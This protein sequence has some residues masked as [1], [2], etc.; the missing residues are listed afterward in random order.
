MRCNNEQQ[1]RPPR[2]PLFESRVKHKSK[3]KSWF[4]PLSRNVK[5]RESGRLLFYRWHV[6][7]LWNIT[8]IILNLSRGLQKRTM[9]TVV[10]LLPTALHGVKQMHIVKPQNCSSTGIFSFK[11]QTHPKVTRPECTVT[12][13][14]ATK[15]QSH[16]N[17]QRSLVNTNSV[18]VSW[19]QSG[20]RRVDPAAQ[21]WRDFRQHASSQHHNMLLL[22][23]LPLP[24][25]A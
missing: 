2:R 20:A 5:W 13:V 19:K 21:W 10:L 1:P 15:T 12:H 25:Q 18:D 9:T 3:S 24:E 11:H 16:K 6:S 22:P 7:L 4:S 8:I 17:I 23:S 14:R